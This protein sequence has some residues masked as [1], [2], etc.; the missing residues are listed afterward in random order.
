MKNKFAPIYLSTV[1]DKQSA[2]IVYALL[3]KGLK[4]NK[5]QS[6]FMFNSDLLVTYNMD[7]KELYDKKKDTDGFLYIYYSDVNPF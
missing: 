1:V 5:T 3:R 7:L 6:V 2:G 4:M